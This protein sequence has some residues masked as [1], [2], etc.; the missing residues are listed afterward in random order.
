[1]N[2]SHYIC[3]LKEQH[4]VDF[5]EIW[6][7]TMYCKHAYNQKRAL[8]DSVEAEFWKDYSQKYDTVPSLIDY[9]PEVLASLAK[10]V[11]SGKDVIEFGCG[12]GKFT[13]P[14]AEMSRSIIGVDFSK[15]MLNQL[16]EKLE[17]HNVENVKLI[18]GKL[19]S[20]DL[21]E[22]DVVYGINA[23]YRM[24]NI[25]TAVEKMRMIS[26]EKVVIV[27]TMQRSLYD[28]ILNATEVKGIGRGQEY[29]QLLNVLYDM[30]IDPSMEMM[31][32][33]KPIQFD[34]LEEHCQSLEKIGRTYGLEVPKL[35]EAFSRKVTEL[36]GN[37]VYH[38]PL[39]VAIISFDS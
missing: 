35:I 29:I 16:E 9:A 13:L 32:V 21:P 37:Y 18:E 1:M 20:V 19:E 3:T 8:D 27:W 14:M 4:G 10:L 26:R 34:S 11:G 30:G 36:E 23:N 15:D 38:C 24:L 2:R 25:R 28:A 5:Q 31:S 33:T 12:T 7:N 22:V 6:R 17:S 39:K